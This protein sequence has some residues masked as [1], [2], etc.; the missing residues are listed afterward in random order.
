M[1][2]PIPL[3]MPPRDPRV[4]LSCRLDKAPVEHAEALLAAYDLLQRLH[5]HG[6]LDLARGAVGSSNQVIETA[7]EAMQSPESIRGMRNLLLIINM[8]GMIEPELLKT[9][10]QAIPPAL[11]NMVRQPE[12]PGLWRLLMDFLWNE[13]FRHGLAAIN[14]LLEAFGNSLSASKNREDREE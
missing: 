13:D 5:D 4:E 6:V 8:L 9:F 1:A 12:A 11:K 10:T 3:E 2:R 14:R 7:V